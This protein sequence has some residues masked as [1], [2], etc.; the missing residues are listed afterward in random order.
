MLI[1]YS[2]RPEQIHKQRPEKEAATEFIIWHFI[3]TREEKDVISEQGICYKRNVFFTNGYQEFIQYTSLS[4]PY[5]SEYFLIMFL[6][7]YSV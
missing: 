2:D 5:N 4:L 6:I 7:P 1:M 3:F